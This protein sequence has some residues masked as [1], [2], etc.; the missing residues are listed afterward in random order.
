MLKKKLKVERIGVKRMPSLHQGGIN[1]RL[2]RMKKRLI[3]QKGVLVRE[4]QKPVMER[5]MSVKNN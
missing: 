3:N 5:L 4:V 1:Q 2:L